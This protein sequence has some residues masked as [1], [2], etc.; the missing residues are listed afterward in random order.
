MNEHESTDGY[1]VTAGARFWD[2]NLRVVQVTE[3]AQ[4]SNK[5]ADTGEV[6]TWHGT[7]GGAS[8]TLTGTMQPFGRLARYF[9]GRDA[10]Q[11]APGTSFKDTH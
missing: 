11:F 8:D 7:T 5:Y 4:H 10:E 6:Q 3:V 9:E 1:P 2:N